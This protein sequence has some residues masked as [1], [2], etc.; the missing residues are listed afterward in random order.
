MATALTDSKTSTAIVGRHQF[1]NLKKLAFNV[2]DLASAGRDRLR[3][4]GAAR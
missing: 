2:C 1:G 3:Q 4:Y